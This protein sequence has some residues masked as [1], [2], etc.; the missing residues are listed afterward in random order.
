M[1][2]AELGFRSVIW[3]WIATC[4]SPAGGSRMYVA[5]ALTRSGSGEIARPGPRRSATT[6]APRRRRAIW[7]RS[8]IRPSGIRPG[9]IPLLRPCAASGRLDA[10]PTACPAHE[11][12]EDPERD[13]EQDQAHDTRPAHA[14]GVRPG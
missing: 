10:S 8:G 6:R 12:D 13:G 11:A 5:S 14:R 4:T 9:A 1:N 7:P 2:W 3:Y